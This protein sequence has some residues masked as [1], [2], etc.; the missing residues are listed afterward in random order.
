MALFYSE[1]SPKFSQ[2][3]PVKL[4]PLM[5]ER[6]DYQG[7]GVAKHQGKTWFV[8]NALPMEIVEVSVLEEKR[9]YGRARAVKWQKMSPHRQ[10]PNCAFYAICGGCQMQ[11]IPL[12]MQREAKQ[13][14]L[15]QRLQR[16]QPTP[17]AFEPMI[18]GPDR[19]YRRRAKLHL[20]WDK[21][22]LSFGFR[23]ANSQQ[24][25]N[26]NNCDVLMPSLSALLPKLHAL[27]S[28]WQRKKQ[29]GHVELVQADNGLC[30]LLRHVG[31]LA[32][33]DKQRL[34][35][36]AE[37][38][39]LLLF[40]MSE[41][42]QVIQW[43]GEPPY[44]QIAGLKLHFSMR[45]FIQVNAEQNEKMVATALEWLELTEQDRVLDLFCGMGNF[46]LPIALQA[47]YVVGVEGVEEMVQQARQNA[48]L[49]GIEN[50]AFYQTDLAQSFTDKPWAHSAFNKVLLDPARSGAAF[51]LEHLCQL[52][53]QRIVYVSC[54]PATLV[55]D[56]EKLIAEGYQLKRSAM[57]DMFPHTVHLES[58]SLFEKIEIPNAMP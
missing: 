46:T 30:M 44:Y 33:V 57:I 28:Q 36:F 31:E 32:E 50:V 45:D 56:A 53:P 18:V 48:E 52:Q 40:V 29:L 8:E 20:N 12:N 54:N 4:P 10:I 47:A 34:L 5:I 17:I 6:L 3:S 21:K 9:Q 7:L 13:Q 1:K 42:G 27:F 39:K 35:D 55:R 11:H 49:N 38:D 58:I 14:A 23:Q 51:A 19:H 15:F 24:I 26:V 41:K 43:R 16:L 25:I 2:K 22:G 37:T